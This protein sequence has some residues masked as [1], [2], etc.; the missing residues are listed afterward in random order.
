[1]RISMQMKLRRASAIGLGALLAATAFAQE[2]PPA[3]PSED[4]A[5]LT[6]ESASA[7]TVENVVTVRSTT[8]SPE[9][10]LAQQQQRDELR[11]MSSVIEESLDRAGLDAWRSLHPG[12]SP[13]ESIVKAEYIPTVGALFRI[14]VNFPL[15][16]PAEEGFA[17]AAKPNSD[18]APDLWEKH[19]R[20]VGGMGGGMVMGGSAGAGRGNHHGGNPAGGRSETYGGGM[21]SRGEGQLDPTGPVPQNGAYS[22][23][24][25]I[26]TP[27]SAEKVDRLK[28]AL[29]EVLARYGARLNCVQP[30][31]RILLLVESPN[32]G[33]FNVN[34][35]MRSPVATPVPP[36]GFPSAPFGQFP[37]ADPQTL[38][39]APPAA[40]PVLPD[41]NPP[42]STFI[43][44][45]DATRN[46]LMVFAPKSALT[47]GQSLEQLGPQQI[48]IKEY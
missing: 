33:D 13:F 35:M 41:F 21:G 48:T 3:P 42:M 18:D 22:L 24:L 40:T 46:R 32:G 7:R 15:A 44:Q 1:M 23:E 34:V 5:D 20:P 9:P 29:S 39:P 11:I 2:T 10:T 38:D 6:Y 25:L 8:V 27:Y 47:A 17:A 12:A 37:G 28:F 43:V 31:E 36:G 14:S 4:T 16:K 19:S 26:A 45:D 30:D